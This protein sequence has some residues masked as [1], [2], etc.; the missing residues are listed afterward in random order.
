MSSDLDPFSD[1]IKLNINDS[2]TPSFEYFLGFGKTFI[3]LRI[4]SLFNIF[5][6]KLSQY[7]ASILD[8]LIWSTSALPSVKQLGYP[9]L[10]NKHC[11][12]QDQNLNMDSKRLWLTYNILRM[13]FSKKMKNTR[14]NS[15]ILHA[16]MLM[17]GI[18]HSNT[19]SFNL[20]CLLQASNV[21][22]SA[23]LSKNLVQKDH[24][25][26]IIYFMWQCPSLILFAF[27]WKEQAKTRRMHT[28]E[29]V[30]PIYSKKK[31][32]LKATCKAKKKICM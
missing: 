31:A 28:K 3:T 15:N 32:L 26:Y 2:N 24:Y 6:N 21:N 12:K 29:D 5:I 11:N 14:I 23:D 1:P 18:V 10:W 7:R 27:S 8:K 20:Y 13:K 19:G 30:A 25:N 9:Y 22:I 17:H 4:Y 16:V